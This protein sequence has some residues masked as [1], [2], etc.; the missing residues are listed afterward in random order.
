MRDETA[1]AGFEEVRDW[2][3]ILLSP[4]FSGWPLNK[5]NKRLCAI[6][7]EVMSRLNQMISRDDVI[8]GLQNREDTRKKF[9]Q[10]LED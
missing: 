4:R 1:S 7:A 3:K 6:N 8:D 10:D 9:M 2:I 5:G